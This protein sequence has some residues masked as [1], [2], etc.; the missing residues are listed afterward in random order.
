M[1]KF[2]LMTALASATLLLSGAAAEAQHRGGGPGDRNPGQRASMMLRAADANGDNSISRDELNELHAEMFEWM[3]RTGDGFL[4][5]ADQ[6]PVNQRMRAIREAR[7][8]EG[9][10]ERRGRH[11]RGPRGGGE[12]MQHRQADTNEDG[13]ISRE[14]FMNMDQI[15]GRFDTN[16]DDL[17]TPDELDAAAENRQNRHRWWR[18]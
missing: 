18:N 10:G 1:N 14:E 9:G 8:E 4:D 17:I 15:F 5:E 12:G 11:R 6:S 2:Q 3:D 16:E 7:M 13:R